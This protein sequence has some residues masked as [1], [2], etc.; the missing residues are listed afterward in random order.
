[1]ADPTNLVNTVMIVNSIVVYQQTDG[2]SCTGSPGSFDSAVGA[3]GPIN[4]LRHRGGTPRVRSAWAAIL[5][6]LLGV[7]F[8]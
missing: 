8:I 2:R 4:P 3:S 5:T 6:A 7:I 1:M